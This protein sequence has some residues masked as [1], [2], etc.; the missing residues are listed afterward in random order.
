M[1]VDEIIEILQ[2]CKVR[3]TA[4]DNYVMVSCPFARFVHEQGKDNHPSLRIRPGTPVRFNCFTCGEYGELWQFVEELAQ[5]TKR[6]ELK[7]LAQKIF[8][9]NKINFEKIIDSRNKMWYNKE[10]NQEFDLNQFEPIE[11]AERFLKERNVTTMLA[12]EYEMRYNS[13]QKMLVFPIWNQGW[14]GAVGRG[15]PFQPKR[16]TVYNHINQ[17]ENFGGWQFQDGKFSVIVE[18]FFDLLRIVPWVRERIGNVYCINGCIFS[19]THAA[20][21]EAEGK[22]VYLFFDNDRAG[23]KCFFTAVKLLKRVFVDKLELN[24]KD[25]GELSR[26][27]FEEIVKNKF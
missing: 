21:L 14:V 7:E 23:Q 18:G 2:I 17:K 19:K 12:K 24:R 1:T 11:K 15:V 3:F 22:P 13:Y 8:Q 16:C 4:Y 25:P 20:L 27:E 9:K 10:W 6:P 26:G 5:L